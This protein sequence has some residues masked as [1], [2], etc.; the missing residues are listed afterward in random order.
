MADDVFNV[1]NI[2]SGV[3]AMQAM[4]G[5]TTKTAEQIRDM[6]VAMK[7]YSNAA[8]SIP[9]LK[10]LDPN[11]Y[12]EVTEGLV[13]MRKELVRQGK[14]VSEINAAIRDVI[15]LRKEEKK[16]ITAEL[17]DMSRLTEAAKQ[18]IKEEQKKA[19]FGEKYIKIGEKH[20]Q[21]QAGEVKSAKQTVSAFAQKGKQL[22]NYAASMAGI[23]L[24]L[25]GILA[26]IIQAIDKSNRLGGMSMQVAAQWGK[27]NNNLK[28]ASGE[29]MK[30]RSGFK[31]MLDQAGPYVI[32][33]ARAGFEM[34]NMER[35]S[36]EIM[37]VEYRTGQSVQEQVGYIKGLVANFGLVDIEA[38][39]YL[40]T[41]REATKTIPMLSMS[42]ATQDW[43]EL[44][45]KT[46]VFNTDLLGTLSLYNT[47]MRKDLAE[48]LGLGDAPRVVRKEIVKTVAGFS[49]DLEDGWKAALGR[50]T[51]AA[52]RLIEFED[53]L[54]EEQFIRMAEFITEKTQGFAGAQ[55][56]LAARKLLGQMG[57]AKEARV[58]LAR[59]FAEGGF[60]TS[61]LKNMMVALKEN[62]IAMEKS[63]KQASRDRDKAIKKGMAIA[64]LLSGLLHD[65]QVWL[66]GL[67]IQLGRLI[68]SL[69]SINEALRIKFDLPVQKA[70]EKIRGG[71]KAL[72]FGVGETFTRLEKEGT[73]ERFKKKAFETEWG[74][75]ALERTKKVA[76]H[77]DPLGLRKG[78]PEGLKETELGILLL[79]AKARAPKGEYEK[80]LGQLGTVHEA[81][82]IR[83]LIMW[84]Q[85]RTRHKT[86]A[87]APEAQSSYVKR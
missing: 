21:L 77:L 59:A 35:L 62:K 80:A 52:A 17:V 66:E 20:H 84:V 11:R 71:I 46:K 81:E 29:I 24:S 67:V 73:F 9:E 49:R 55:R 64:D 32:S 23:Q 43:A 40:E 51:T 6:E 85:Q 70:G 22:A 44:I 53:I 7:T 78:P 27:G 47:L 26:L 37:A 4:H 57:F 19:A 68:N 36:K 69:D 18:R 86:L 82:A 8:A 15:K 63:R 42:E 58:E 41:V 31:K 2:E 5:V 45:D 61:G 39:N 72:P 54:P 79:R 87:K 83:K 48:E 1:T 3:E 38:A 60:D 28:V 14:T 33:L 10:I 75:K 56:E 65:L 16:I 25:A 30:I 34:K 76:G 13:E 12:K 50:G 74:K